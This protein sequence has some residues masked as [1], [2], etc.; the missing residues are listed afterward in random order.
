MFWRRPKLTPEEHA[1]ALELVLRD[2]DP[3]ERR[4]AEALLDRMTNKDRGE[5][6]RLFSRRRPP[7]YRRRAPPL[8]SQDGQAR[9]AARSRATRLRMDGVVRRVGI[10]Y[11]CALLAAPLGMAL[12]GVLLMHPNATDGPTLPTGRAILASVLWLAGLGLVIWNPLNSDEN[13]ARR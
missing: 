2:L 5:T 1:R 8:S 11:L 13:P 9:R 7:E 10:Y 6:E 4:R 12:F 3:A